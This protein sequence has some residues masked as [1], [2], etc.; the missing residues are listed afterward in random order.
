MLA[1]FSL[2]DNHLYVNDLV[3]DFEGV[4]RYKGVRISCS[5][6]DLFDLEKQTGVLLH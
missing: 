4:T 6:R 1:D 5:S 3:L 2:L